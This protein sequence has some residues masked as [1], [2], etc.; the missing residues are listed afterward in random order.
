MSGMTKAERLEEM[1]RLY[2]QRA[3]ADIELAD[4]LGVTRETVFRDRRE[5]TTQY[6]IEKDDQGRYHI[7]RTKL[8]SEIKL[9]LHEALTLY[10]AG[11]KTSRQTRF[12]QPH[13]VNAVE[14]L[15]ATLRQ[16]MTERLL[17]S[18]EQLMGQEKNPEK[19]K[20]IE[21]VTQ[22]W[23]EQR[24]VR[25]EYQALGNE[26]LTR[27]TISP[28]IIEPSIWSDSVYVVAR[29]D[30]NDR[31]F[32]FK[33]DRILS[34]VL[35]GETF[36]IPDS[37][38]DEELLKHAWGIWY[39]DR[40]PVTVRLRFSPAVTR[41]VK[42]SIW[43][44][45]EKVDDSEDG[46]CLWSVEIAEWREMLPWVRGWGADVEVLEPKGLRE[47]LIREA[48]GLAELYK[49]MEM[50]KQFVAHIRKKDKT[51]QSLD[52]HLRAVS[53]HAGDFAS[54][55]GLKETGDVLG[56]FHDFGK[57]SEKFQR[58]ILS[59]EGSIHPDAEEYL[60][61]IA[62]KGKIDH[63][64]A[65]A[66]VIYENLWN[67]GQKEKIAAQ[68]LALCIASHHSGLID[69]LKPDGENNFKRRM[70]KADENTR[71]AEALTNLQE[72]VNSLDGLLSD[73]VVAQIFDKL[74]SLKE[75]ANESQNTLAFKAGLLVR[76]LLSC[77]LDADRLDTADFESPGNV[78]VRNYGQYHPWE[79]LIERL[80]KQ[81]QEFEQKTSQMEL[82][83][84]LEVNQL[85]AQ[86]AQACLDTATK[87]KGI[88]QL[89]V[90]TGGGKTLAS[91]RFA[92]N[93]AK[94][95][96]MERVFYIIPYTSIIDQNADEIRKILEDKDEGG[97]Y[98]DKVV[99][100][101]HSNLTPEE[102][103]YRQNLL[104]QNWDA[105]VVLTTQ[106]QFLEALFGY[107]TRSARRMHQL[108]NSVIIFDEV[109]RI[110]INMIHMFNLALRF[111]VHTCGATVVLCTATQPP[112]DKVENPY[113]ALTIKPEQRIIQSEEK[114]FERLK[115]VEVFDKRKVGGWSA[116]EVAEL[117]EGQLQEK[118]SVLVVVNTKKS[119]RALYQA[120]A[121]RK[122]PCIHLYHLS[123]NMCPAHRLKMLNKIKGKLKS[124][125]AK[126]VICVST[127]L[128]EAGVDIDFGAVI[129]YLAGMDSIAQSAGRCNRHG[130]REGLGN[131]WIVNPQ[132]ENIDR[133]KDIVIGADNAQRVLDDFKGNPNLIGLEAMAAY[134]K[135]YYY[136]RKD[137]M[138][139]KVGVKEIGRDDDL[140]NLLSLNTLSVGAYQGTHK[141]APE[142]AFPQSFQSAAKAFRV[143]DSPTRGVVVPYQ[144]G[145]E[146]I[147]DL[148]RAP[149]LEKEY[150]LLKRA[151]RY[152]VN[153]FQR[154]FDNLYKAGAIYEVQKGAGV[155]YLDKQ[156]YS[157]YF[158]WSEEPV[159]PMEVQIV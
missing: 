45:L 135:Y 153:L 5:L 28:Y 141:T 132:G 43:H 117:A 90:P 156:Y 82:G 41:R 63:T 107:G 48:Q 10:L 106:V 154:D 102:E 65:G 73:K 125:T 114:L 88:Y 91:L 138:R 113:R 142:L 56:L 129:R 108:A 74:Q 109:Q 66:Q 30:F 33:I 151:Q 94:E 127:Q 101:H 17:K 52:E 39:A 61:P 87:P 36:E 13:T 37:F 116:E 123:T 16:P 11:R 32:A 71:K 137:E 55:I 150:K 18:A 53:K 14:K 59:G 103:S 27:H 68:V 157:K 79:I 121:N 34:A 22:A 72:I 3:Y 149:E 84:A 8:I 110:P 140:F 23:V 50:K 105:P 159:N 98:L 92:L 120:I 12:H 35:S 81:F 148:C 131:V 9:N 69:C 119:A 144:E 86:V 93:H 51:P 62:H 89:T 58:Y 139:Y 112:L 20:I 54:K 44:P 26:G 31:V 24:K 4:R 155:F 78:H 42:E 134:F 152:S 25:I 130:V 7:P 1:K 64:T 126:P 49:V 60:D 46:G 104:A 111:L 85:R 75:E 115:R 122:I 158:G 6:P 77:L 2:I 38:N 96:S 80:E 19:I 97:N 95:H 21:T 99:L 29:S 57:A 124:K 67:K 100:E 136:V 147:K 76:F 146:I 70:D 47:H 40:D 128:I 133:L 15:A 145:D 118:G 143:I 83:K